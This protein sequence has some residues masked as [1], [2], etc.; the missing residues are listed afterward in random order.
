VQGA[1]ASGVAKT[2]DF[3]FCKS[4]EPPATNDARA[5]GHDYGAGRC[6]SGESGPCPRHFA[7]SM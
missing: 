3:K 1:P 2:G 5:G 7:S 4:V 6:C